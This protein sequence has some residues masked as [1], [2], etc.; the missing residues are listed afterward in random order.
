ML[1]LVTALV[2]PS[3]VSVVSPNTNAILPT[4]LAVWF[5]FGRQRNLGNA[6]PLSFRSGQVGNRV[7]RVC[8]LRSLWKIT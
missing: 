8:T 7:Q 2:V 5:T 4:N 6:L 3:R 1:L